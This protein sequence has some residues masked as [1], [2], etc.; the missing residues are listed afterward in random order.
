M[1]NT[2]QSRLDSGLEFPVKDLEAFRVDPS[3]LGCRKGKCLAPRESQGIH[4]PLPI[5][6]PVLGFLG[7]GLRDWVWGISWM[8]VEES[9]LADEGNPGYLL[10]TPNKSRA[11]TTSHEPFDLHVPLCNAA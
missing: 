3:S 7:F 5:S 2:R 1:A 11:E 8:P 4:P 9:A 10:S 6:R